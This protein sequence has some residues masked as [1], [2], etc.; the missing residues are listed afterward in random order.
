VRESAGFQAY[1]EWMPVRQPAA[2]GAPGELRPIYRRLSFGTLMDLFMLDLRQYR[3]LQPAS[4][5]DSATINNPARTIMGATQTQWL[6]GNLAGST[7]KWKMMGNSVQITPII[8][9]PTLLDAPTQGLLQQFFGVPVGTPGAVPLN[10]DSW[11]GYASSRLQILGLIGG[12]V[13]GRP[14]SNC[15]FLTGDIHSSYACDIPVNPATYGTTPASLATEFVCTSL[16]SDNINEIVGQPERIPNGSG[17]YIPNP[18]T[19]SFRSLIQGFNAWVKDVNLDFHGFSI[20]DVTAQR[21]QVDNWVIRSD[22]ND[23]YAGDPRI[24][25]NAGCVFRSALQTVDLTQRVTPAA[26]PLGPRL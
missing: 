20:V 2:T 23:A 7:A 9:V 21:T 22:A 8:V 4:P 25:P 6:Q 12:A 13:T 19:A 10:T 11:D 16:T 1:Y 18:A 17:G 3:D 24:D 26:G 15:V 14:V 5:A